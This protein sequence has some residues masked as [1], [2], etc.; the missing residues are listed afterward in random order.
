MNNLDF[1]LTYDHWAR[2]RIMYISVATG[3]LVGGVAE[4]LSVPFNGAVILCVL[5][6]GVV[7][8]IGAFSYA[9]PSRKEQRAIIALPIRRNLIFAAFSAVVMLVL[10]LLRI[11]RMEV[12]AFE[13][14]LQQASD[15]PTMPQSIEDA[16]L[17]TAQAR[18][19]RVKIPQD[20]IHAAG[21]KFIKAT[22][23]TP[24]AWEAALALIDYRTS[25]NA[26]YSPKPEAV[27]PNT[28][29][30]Q[31][32]INIKPIPQGSTARPMRIFTAGG[33]APPEDSARIETL[34]NP[35][36]PGAGSRYLIVEDGTGVILLDGE[37]FK[38]VIV[39]DA[40]VEYGGGRVH[41]E[42]VWF[43]DC[44][45]RLTYQPNGQRLANAILESPAV[46]FT[47]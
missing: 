14:K 44:M 19:A 13:R 3:A 33:Y 17:I 43:V 21:T 45:I 23:H 7:E 26:G 22:Q 9:E 27:G 41:L 47:A 4:L 10:A 8:M 38:N 36:V 20:T 6:T 31:F 29:E 32:A 15:H 1:Y 30:H 46:T 18:A 11:P 39:R 37:H 5:A 2:R 12:L 16:K 34:D 24:G 25:L 28:E 42:N 40:F 35:S